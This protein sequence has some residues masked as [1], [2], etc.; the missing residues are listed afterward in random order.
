MAVCDAGCLCSSLRRS[1][2]RQRKRNKGSVTAYSMLFKM[3]VMRTKIS[4]GLKIL[5]IAICMVVMLSG[6]YPPAQ[7]QPSIVPVLTVEDAVQDHSIASIEKEQE[8]QKQTLQAQ[9]TAVQTNG[10]LIAGMQGEERG[11]G[12]LLLLIQIA[13]IVFQVRKKA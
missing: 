9:W 3:R 2:V 4:I 11:I 7:A 8:S 6:E 12:A 5:F 10:N 13:S 1:H